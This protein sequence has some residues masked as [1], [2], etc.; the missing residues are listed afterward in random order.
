LE[1]LA[2]NKSLCFNDMILPFAMVGGVAFLEYA[3]YCT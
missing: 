3:R 1:F 2:A